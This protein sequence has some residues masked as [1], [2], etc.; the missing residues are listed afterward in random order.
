MKRREPEFYIEAIIDAQ[1]RA[2]QR[3]AEQLISDSPKE[4]TY[5]IAGVPALQYVKHIK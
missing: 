3:V 2:S 1:N 4:V 5:K